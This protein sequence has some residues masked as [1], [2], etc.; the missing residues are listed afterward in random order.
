MGW[1]VPSPGWARMKAAPAGLG[2]QKW[3]F[4]DLY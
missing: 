2:V 1:A 3:A 4:A